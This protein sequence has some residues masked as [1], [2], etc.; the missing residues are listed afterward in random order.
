MRQNRY[1]T[2]ICG[3]N[4]GQCVFVCVGV[5]LQMH[6]LVAQA[7]L[8]GMLLLSGN[9]LTGACHTAILG[10]FLHLYTS[11]RLQVDTT[12][13]FRQLPQQKKQRFALLGSHLL[14]FVMVVYRWVYST[15]CTTVSTGNMLSSRLQ[16]NSGWSTHWLLHLS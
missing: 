4:K 15:T 8:A 6:E 5:C 11:K 1:R 13:A 16:H 12:E 3:R 10:Y 7:L 2:D 14:L 9:W